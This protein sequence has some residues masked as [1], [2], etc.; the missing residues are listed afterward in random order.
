MA[1]I[2]LLTIHWGMSFGAVMQTYATC[3]LLERYG[4]NVS[5]LNLINPRLRRGYANFRSFL[6]AIMDFQFYM[7]KHQYFSNLGKKSYGLNYTDINNVDTIIVGSDQVWNRDI[8]QPLELVYFL[9]EIKDVK[10]ISLSSSFG[11][12]VWSE[13]PDYTSRVKELLND[14]ATLSV[15]E[16]SGKEILEKVF[17][18]K[19]TVL[20]D[21]TL[22]YGFFD[23]LILT[24]CP[25]KQIYTFFINNSSNYNDLVNVI[26]NDRKLSVFKHSKISYYFKNGPRHRLTY[27]KNSSC[28]L[29]DS[30]HGVAFSVI[31]R[32]EFFVF[33]GES[34]KFDRIQNL[35]SLLGLEDRFIHSEDDYKHRKKE[36]G[37]IDYNR[38]Y[39]K[40]LEEQKRVEDFILKYI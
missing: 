37:K 30:F 3:K 32:K 35:L 29:T 28:I 38:V 2:K 31:F 14:F 9:N 17:N 13:N 20:I 25:K 36:I 7:F 33:C 39:K 24:D 22:A 8:S 1:N 15:R 23:D 6:C 21:P 34:S 18:I 12:T 11:K 4:H 10:K 16:N 26:S 5:V 40:L 19:S 27:L